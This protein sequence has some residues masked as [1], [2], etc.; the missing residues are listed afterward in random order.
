MSGEEFGLY[1]VQGLTVGSTYVLV[2]L[3]LSLVYGISGIVNFTSGDLCA[4]GALL[5]STLGIG[6]GLPLPL[7]VIS[8][9]LFAGA[10]AV[11]VSLVALPPR[12]TRR[13]RPRSAHAITWVIAVVAASIV[14]EELASIIWGIPQRPV[15]TLVDDSVVVIRNVPIRQPAILLVCSAVALALIL[16]LALQRSRWG[17]R[18]RAAGSDSIGASL[19]GINFRRLYTEVFLVAGAVAGLAG[20]LAGA[21]TFASP[22]MGFSL[23]IKGFIAGVIGGLGS[24]RG[25]LIGGLSLGVF[26][27]FAG[28]LLGVQWQDLLTLAAFVAVLIVSPNGIIPR[29]AL[30]RV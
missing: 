8:A 15:P 9:M 4:L 22:F 27:T 23:T 25:A 29:R 16:D 13:T 18:V 7:T 12:L 24:M 2:A 11:V 26:E 1:L 14:I 21:L 19:V 17:A 6:H 30:R 5:A 10:I 28:F 20:V 3:S